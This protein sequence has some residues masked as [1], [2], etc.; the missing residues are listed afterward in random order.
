MDPSV[1]YFLHLRRRA[2]SQ[3]TLLVCQQFAMWAS[4][5]VLLVRETVADFS[6]RLLPKSRRC[7]WL[8]AWR[9]MRDWFA[10]FR[11]LGVPIIPLDKSVTPFTQKLCITRRYHVKALLPADLFRVGLALRLLQVQSW[12]KNYTRK[13]EAVYGTITFLLGTGYTILFPFC[14]TI[15]GATNHFIEMIMLPHN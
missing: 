10:Y 15:P 3:N 5:C 1:G 2:V 13:A 6:C 7:L 9:P 4:S 14:K 11:L 8:R 12:C